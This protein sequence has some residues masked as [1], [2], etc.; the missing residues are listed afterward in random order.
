MSAGTKI[1]VVDDEPV[2]LDSAR[3]ILGSDRVQVLTAPDAETAL[4][5][6]SEAPDI[7]I[8]DLVL[9]GM[10]GMRLLEAA[11]EHDPALLIIITTGFSTVENAVAALKHGAFDFLPKPFT[12]DE[13]QASVSRAA[14]AVELRLTLG[15]RGPGSMRRGDFQLGRQTWARPEKDGTARLGVTGM[16]LQTVPLIARLELPEIGAE[17]RQGGRLLCLVTGDGMAHSLWSPLGGRVIERNDPLLARPEALRD[18]PVGAGWIVR[19]EPADL[20]GDLP[21]LTES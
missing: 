10:S 1:L 11:L 12:C 14:R 2:I 17:L 6:L 13:L 3:K 7:L 5:L 21:N 8:S 16:Q 9:P 15:G 19:I 18:D 20:D 4:P